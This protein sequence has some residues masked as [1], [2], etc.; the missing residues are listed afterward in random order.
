MA[1]NPF[2]DLDPNDR[3]QAIT[4]LGGAN[5]EDLSG[6]GNKLK[7]TSRLTKGL[8][9][10]LRRKN[11]NVKSDY[12]RIR[13]LDTR[14]KR[15]IPIIPGMG[16]VAGSLYGAPKP[17]VPST[18]ATGGLPGRLPKMPRPARRSPKPDPKPVPQTQPDFSNIREIIQKLIEFGY[19]IEQIRRILGELGEGF[20]TPVAAAPLAL[21]DVASAELPGKRRSPSAPGVMPRP[22]P[23]SV[24]GLTEEQ[25]KLSIQ[26]ERALAKGTNPDFL[27]NAYKVLNEYFQK[28]GGASGSV[29][30]PDGGILTVSRGGL[31]NP[32]PIFN[33]KPGRQ[34][35]AA[36]R[37]TAEIAKYAPLFQS[38]I[39]IMGSVAGITSKGKSTNALA[40]TALTKPTAVRPL[41]ET[42]LKTPQPQVRPDQRPPVV[43]PGSTT[44][45]P[46]LGGATRQPTRLRPI[47]NIFRTDI[48]AEDIRIIRQLEDASLTA[49]FEQFLRGGFSVEQARRDF[50]TTVSPARPRT[51]SKSGPRSLTPQQIERLQAR[52]N[53]YLQRRIKINNY[54]GKSGLKPDDPEALPLIQTLEAYVNPSKV[55]NLPQGSIGFF[56]NLQNFDVRAR[57]IEYLMLANPPKGKSVNLNFINKI[58][59]S[60][61]LS[62]KPPTQVDDSTTRFFL[63]F[64]K[65]EGINPKPFFDQLR[66]RGL[67]DTE[68]IRKYLPRVEK[69]SADPTRKTVPIDPRNIRSAQEVSFESLNIDTSRETDIYI[70]LTGPK[71]VAV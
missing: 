36:Q 45:G 5:P 26:G 10:V 43:Q 34:W 58:L 70:V 48:T 55:V 56:A 1:F 30:T 35:V 63:N 53:E 13:E 64:F 67:I 38:V 19:T 37:Q 61:G 46:R 71:P 44:V 18:P 24:P 41:P 51:P 6:I 2:F 12:D 7:T 21:D 17:P 20:G 33:Y 28:S 11:A 16:G 27:A 57:F 29:P 15:V 40:A 59:R 23:I 32:R 25:T 22:E 49:Q 50:E 31:F 42:Y 54:F 68:T 3:K 69:E 62:G 47:P 60:S 14:I 4:Q 66:R 9:E 39:D 8:V 65:M 52:G